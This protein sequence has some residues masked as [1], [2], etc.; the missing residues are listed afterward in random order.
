MFKFLS[1]QTRQLCLTPCTVLT[2]QKAFSVSTASIIS[3]TNVTASLTPDV[4]QTGSLN[5]NNDFL[6]IPGGF[7]VGNPVSVPNMAFDRYCGERLNSLPGNNNSTT[8]CSK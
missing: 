2:T 7:N 4:S 8:I 3:A 5:C 6:V 1:E